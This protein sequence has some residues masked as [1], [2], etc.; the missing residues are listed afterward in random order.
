VIF[1][2]TLVPASGVPL[3]KENPAYSRMIHDDIA[4]T[5]D[6]TTAIS[7][8]QAALLIPGAPKSTRDLLFELL[9]PAPGHYY[10]AALNLPDLTTLNIAGRDGRPGRVATNR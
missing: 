3:A 8:E 5:P 4:A 6:G 9:E 1:Y 7:R 10:A 2:S